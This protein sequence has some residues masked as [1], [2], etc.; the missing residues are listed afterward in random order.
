MNSYQFVM[1]VFSQW[2]RVIAWGKTLP[3]FQVTNE[4]QITLSVMLIQAYVKT[5][6]KIRIFSKI[7]LMWNLEGEII[8][9]YNSL[10]FQTNSINNAI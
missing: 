4:L 1:N 7:K 6:T 3:L 2:Q 10:Y 9:V 8:N 5:N